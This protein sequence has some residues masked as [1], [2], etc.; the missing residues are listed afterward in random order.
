MLKRI[1]L[2]ML[3][4]PVVLA[5]AATTLLAQD[6]HATPRVIDP[7]FVDATCAACQDFYQFATGGWKQR[8]S[9]S[10]RSK[11]PSAL[12]DSRQR[13]IEQLR[14]LLD[15]FATHR[16]TLTDPIAR[17]LGLFYASCKE[18]ARLDQRDR[19]ELDWLVVGSMAIDS[20]GSRDIQCVKIADQALGPVLGRVYIKQYFASPKFRTRVA[21][22]ATNVKAA[23]RELLSKSPWLDDPSRAAA[24]AKLQAIKV[25]VAYP[26]AWPDERDLEITSDTSYRLNVLAASAFQDQS[27]LSRIGYPEDPVRWQMAMSESEAHAKNVSSPN[28]IVF[29]AAFLQPPLFDTLADDAAN[30]GAIGGFIGHAITYGFVGSD[31]LRSSVKGS[32][33]PWITNATET[34]YRERA[35]ALNTQLIQYTVQG[36]E[37]DTWRGLQEVL[38]DLVGLQAAYTAFQKTLVGKPRPPSVNGFTPQQRF[39]LAWA[40]IWAS[41]GVPKG[42]RDIPGQWQV[43]VPLSNMPAFA[44]AWGCKAGTFM[45][46]PKDARVV[47]W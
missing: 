43:N 41:T 13:T 5:S 4:I 28:E 24:L 29:P 35:D 7:T 18:S 21:A 42:S 47:I 16:T 25:K 27:R 39:F 34:K 17:K 19:Q 44:E 38:P 3:S 20:L 31:G 15:S 2:M 1:A 14:R 9:V 22:I 40:Q 30:Y 6:R 45:M 37:S 10:D 32:F 46:R 11:L 33:E 23:F 26:D 36:V 8:P 12:E